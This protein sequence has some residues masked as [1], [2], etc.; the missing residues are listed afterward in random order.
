MHRIAA[1]SILDEQSL[2]VNQRSFC[3]IIFHSDELADS[4][5]LFG[6]LSLLINGQDL[7]EPLKLVSVLCFLRAF[8]LVGNPDNRRLDA[9]AGNRERKQ[10][11]RFE[12]PVQL[13]GV[14][15][16]DAVRI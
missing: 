11:S 10:I 3:A 13:D 1:G 14:A 8:Y 4:D 15:R 12:S 7:D 2:G 6:R 16:R 9:A 5:L